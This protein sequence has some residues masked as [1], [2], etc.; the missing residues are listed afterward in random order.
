MKKNDSPSEL[1]TKIQQKAED[2]AFI[3][4]LN[5]AINQGQKFEELTKE[6]NRSAREIF[7]G[8][9]ATLYLLSEDERFLFMQ[10]QSLAGNLSRQIEKIIQQKISNIKI[11]LTANSEYHKILKSGQP[12]IINDQNRI[13]RMMEECTQNIAL[14]KFA[15]IVA[16]LIGYKSLITV[17]LIY[18]KQQIGIIDIGREQAFTKSEK[19]RFQALAYQVTSL[20]MY[21]N[22]NES[23]EKSEENYRRLVENLQEAVCSVNK[24]SHIT[25][26]NPR[27]EAILGYSK[28]EII[29]KPITS[30]LADKFKSAFN[31]FWKKLPRENPE[32]IELKFLN[33]KKQKV[34]T[35]LKSSPVYDEMDNFDGAILTLVDITKLRREEEEREILYKIVE[36][37]GT[38]TNLN[39]L[40]KSIYENITKVMPAQ[41]C[42]IALYDPHSQFVSFPLW[43][44]QKDP[45]PKPRKRARGMTEYVLSNGK[46]ALLSSEDIKKLI[47]QKKIIRL[48]TIPNVWL[49]V[50]L[51]IHSLPLGVLVVQNYQEGHTYSKDD[52]D[53]LIAIGQQAAFA[54]ERKMTEEKIQNQNLFMN[55]I[56]ESLTHPFCVID[57]NTYQI[58]I[59]N[60]SAK[61]DQKVKWTTC[62]RLNHNQTEPCNGK[63]Y[64]CPIQ[65][66]KKTKKPTTLEHVHMDNKGNPRHVEIHAYPIFD[67]KGEVTEIIEYAIDI[68][69]RKEAEQANL[70]SEA[71]HRML[72]EQSMDGIMVVAEGRIE[73]VNQAFC[74]IH[75]SRREELIGTNP[76]DLIYKED[77]AKAMERIKQ[78]LKGDESLEETTYRAQRSDGSFIWAEVRS[79]PFT[80][81][82]KKMFQSI[83][84]DITDRKKAEE[85]MQKSEKLESLSILAGGIAHDFNNIL[86]GILGN[87]SLAKIN[88]S[89]GNKIAKILLE[90]ENA[91]IRAKSL[92]QQL[93]TFAKGGVP[94]KNVISIADLIRDSASFALRGSRVKCHFSIARNLWT[95]AVDEGQMSQVINNLIINADM[96]M[97][98]G[99][100]ITVNVGNIT[101]TRD[102]P[103]PL[104]EGRYIQIDIV[105]EGI[106]IKKDHLAKIF[107]PY[108]TTKQKGSGLGLAT[109]Y[110]I[111]KKHR[112]HIIVDSILGSGTTF[113]LYLPA[114]E[115][116]AKKKKE[117]KPSK[118]KTSLKV[119]IM[120]DDESIRTVLT[121]MLHYMGSQTV[122]AKDGREAIKIYQ[123]QKRLN[124]P[125]DVVIMDLTV[126]GGM[127]GR[128]TIANLLKIDPKVKAIV[129]SGYSNDPII[130]NYSKYGF[131]GFVTKPFKLEELAKILKQVIS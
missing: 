110:S 90:A 2:L 58:K 72:F 7:C 6:V 81:E 111:V 26:A 59:S 95:V 131:Q 108:F 102:N 130:A 129:S 98:E 4:S 11:K 9:G 49:G 68:T 109:S 24:K 53:L 16:K 23:L 21:K 28:N 48:G 112:G 37:V 124:K 19:Q 83:I 119:L 75:S 51:Y 18:E 73:S 116:I 12:Q 31:K 87:I 78:L 13:V 10:N 61:K 84:R 99:G 5:Q 52:R 121:K 60:S 113:T 25:F 70:R 122:A 40:L 120:D 27:L 46:A 88:V 115:S 126:P 97:P 92:T 123:K 20:I 34:F 114:A 101:L 57:V 50:P 105:D 17:P 74:Q 85:E 32:Q 42:Y 91:A 69:E 128:E 86:T 71:R 29:G 41:N 44:D 45:A 64:P 79:S 93:L 1:P 30:F 54:I 35:R 100:I 8:R 104:P 47:K 39:E 118:L 14:K 77:Q 127:G 15:P 3:N 65:E 63:S 36:N 22:S 107:D 76:K 89:E 103:V 82:G 67:R 106:G 96:A 66:V 38:T 55:T 80:W 43:R 33:K 56:L 125:F 62:Y 117:L 94:V